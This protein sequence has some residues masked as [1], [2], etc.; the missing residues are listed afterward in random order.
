MEFGITVQPGSCWVVIGHAEAPYPAAEIG[1]REEFT[2][3]RNED[4]FDLPSDTIRLEC[5]STH[6]RMLRAVVLLRLEIH[7][8]I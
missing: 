5:M 7:G 3:R 4:G 2:G 6:P 8:D 1:S